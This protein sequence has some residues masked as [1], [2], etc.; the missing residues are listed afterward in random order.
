R[1][2]LS[3]EID[4]IVVKI[5]DLALQKRLGETAHAPRWATAWKFVPREST[6]KIRDIIVQVGRTGTVTP[7][8]IFDPIS[9]SGVVV[10]R[11]TLHNAA[12]VKEKDIRIGDTVLVQR[13]GDVIPEIAA[14]LT[15][16][17]TGKERR[18]HMP[19]SC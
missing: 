3:F 7:V 1:D 14:V 16:R 18:F 11:A 4:G 19:A 13:A 12:F 6:T 5:D 15:E 2:K 17:R 9:I 8:A 10:E